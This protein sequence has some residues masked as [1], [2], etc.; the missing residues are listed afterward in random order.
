MQFTRLAVVRQ[1]ATVAIFVAR[2]LAGVVAYRG[3]PINQLPSVNIPIVTITTTYPGANPQE[4]ETRISRPIEDA[5][6]G[7][8]HIERI[9]SVSGQ[10]FSAVTVVFTDAADAREIGAEV[11]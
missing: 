6:A 10:G 7:L 11:E 1:S 4:I 8:S 5:V 3:L 9:A 2:A